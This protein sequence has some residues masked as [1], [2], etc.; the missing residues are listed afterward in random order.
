MRRTII[1]AAGVVAAILALLALL[2]MGSAALSDPPVADIDPGALTDASIQQA[3]QALDASPDRPDGYKRLCAA[4]LQKARDTGDFGFNERADLALRRALELAPDDG[5]AL[6]LQA[7]LLMVYHRFAE[8]LEAARRLEQRRPDDPAVYGILVDA[9][10]E[11]GDYDEAV[12]AADRLVHL[13][14]GTAA[15]ARIA[16]LR[17]LHGDP[18]GAVEA[19]RMAAD[20]AA[21]DEPE[22]QAWCR[23][24]LGLE[25][26]N[27][28]R[29]DEAEREID[30]ALERFPNYHLALAAKGRARVSA[31]DRAGAIALYQQAQARV[32][33]LDTAVALG[34]LYTRE[35][36]LEEAKRQYQLVE[37]IERS[38][39][40]QSRTWSR[41][42]ALFWA[43]HD[44]R[45]E[46]ALA[47]ARAERQKRSDIYT[48]DA[49]AWCLLKAGKAEEAR[50]ALLEALRLGTRDPRL[51]YHAGMI[52]H[53]LGDR[54][55]AA[56]YL[57]A[58]LD[59]DPGFDV[60]QAEV[61]KRTLAGLEPEEGKT[62]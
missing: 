13:E 22:S 12:K 1:H 2:R 31:G 61:A 20:A 11:Q 26:L 27:A 35:G 42:L 8:A 52:Y 50:A 28:G 18:E 53:R 39:S 10:V 7:S 19:M 25:L 17:E 58:A 3:R 56:R 33:L 48:C 23:V 62:R 40:A 14:P 24:Y 49:L 41:Q 6:T 4:Y 37:F 36:R 9:L 43:D 5:E 54:T 47:A 46:E 21:P 51:L 55:Q 15:Y 29:R 34:D 57:E 60:L 32:P 30:R 16:Y 59:I 45:P 44:L 38:G